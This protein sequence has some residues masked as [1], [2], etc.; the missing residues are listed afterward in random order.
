MVSMHLHVDTV[1][2]EHTGSLGELTHPEYDNIHI[3]LLEN[4]KLVT[5]KRQ[6]VLK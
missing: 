4:G 5:A 3:P 2:N 6:A 1:G